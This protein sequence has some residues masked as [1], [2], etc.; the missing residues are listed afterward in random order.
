MNLRE[1]LSKIKIK[2]DCVYPS[3]ELSLVLGVKLYRKYR[4]P[5]NLSDSK[6]FSAISI[7]VNHWPKIKRLPPGIKDHEQVL[8]NFLDILYKKLVQLNPE[9]KTCE[10]PEF[11][12]YNYPNHPHYHIILGALSRFSIEDIKF[13]NQVWHPACCNDGIRIRELERK[14]KISG[15]GFIASTQTQEKILSSIKSDE[16]ILLL[17]I[18]FIV[19]EALSY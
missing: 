3:F 16:K 2:E 14:Q 6:I 19:E 9:L 8:I 15:L 12:N 4:M 7:M 13:F 18:D 5:H 10:N 1:T 17:F 11:Y